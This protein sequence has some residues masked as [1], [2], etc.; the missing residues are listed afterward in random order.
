STPLEQT[1]LYWLAV[2][3]ELVPLAGLLADL[4]E[5]MPQREVLAALESLLRRMLIERGSDRPTFTL[6]PI[7]REYLTDQL[8][9]AICQEL[10]DGQ[11]QLL[12][13]YALVQATARDYVRRSQEQL[14]A[15]AL[16][17]RLAVV[18]GGAGAVELQLLTVLESWRDKPLIEVGYGPGNVINLLRLL[19]GHLRGLDLT[20]LAIRQAYL[21]GVEAQDPSRA[22][23]SIHDSVFA[24][25]FDDILAVAIS[26][27][28][29]Y[30]AASSRRGDI[31]VWEAGGLTLR[32]AWRAH[33][34]AIWAIAFSP[35]GRTIA[36]GSW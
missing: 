18:A 24:E 34:N 20:R 13:R 35:D 10:V 12:Q 36:S 11:S 7:V 32:R 14:I 3:R 16:L 22:D 4:G 17:E 9:R 5:V 30:W 6:Q 1:L 29:A 8:V 25:T 26:S 19:R 21:Q 28:G 27:T 15:S 31:L 23:A 2:E 33:M